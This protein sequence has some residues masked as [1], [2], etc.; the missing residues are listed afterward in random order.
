MR[1]EII[2]FA[3][4]GDDEIFVDIE[5]REGES[6]ERRRLLIP[7]TV[8]VDMRLCRGECTR[9]CFEALE[10]ESRVYAAYKRAICILGFGA[11]SERMLVSKLTAKGFERDIAR[12]AVVRASAC[13]FLPEVE[14]AKREAERCASRLWGAIRIRAHLGS[15]GYG[16]AAIDEA[17]FALEDAGVDFGENCKRLIESKCKKLP[18][19]RAELQKLI[20]S[21]CRYGYSL[22]EVRSA[23]AEIASR[24]ESIYD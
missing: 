13:G 12:A 18:K 17:M 14:N 15:R 10:Y 1:L 22:G 8:Y 2:S 7:S 21:V 20:A 11:C 9:E 23:C 4:G 16:K 5:L 6:F 19:D 24:K 3:A